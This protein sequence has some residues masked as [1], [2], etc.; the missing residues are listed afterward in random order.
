MG[1]KHIMVPQ[2]CLALQKGSWWEIKHVFGP[3]V[4]LALQDRLEIMHVRVP[5]STVLFLTS[6]CLGDGR[7]G[8]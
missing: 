2:L 4:C 3:H 8:M 5:Q 6:Q 1:D 7:L